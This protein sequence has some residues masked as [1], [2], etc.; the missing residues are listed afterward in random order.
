MCC[1]ARLTRH[2]P[3]SGGI[4]SRNLSSPVCSVHVYYS[5]F[6]LLVCRL[7]LRVITDEYGSIAQKI[8]VAYQCVVVSP[9]FCGF[10]SLHCVFSSPN[11]LT[12]VASCDTVRILYLF[13]RSDYRTGVSVCSYGSVRVVFLLRFFVSV[14][15]VI[16]RANFFSLVK[17]KYS[18][19][20]FLHRVIN[21]RFV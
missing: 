12:V 7:Q 19:L 10:L 2:Y 8:L 16:V 14:A 17:K 20:I 6:V 21:C 3:V 15:V 9:A 4:H 11:V 18:M 13:V 5:R 1:C